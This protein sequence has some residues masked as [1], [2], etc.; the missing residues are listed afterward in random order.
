M[1]AQFFWHF[2]VT[3]SRVISI[4]LLAS[5]F[6]IYTVIAIGIHAFTMTCWVFLL[7]RSPFCS[8][9]SFHSFAFSMV[10]GTVFIF[11]YILPKEAKSTFWHYFCFYT[12]TGIENI[13]A[14]IMFMLFSTLSET[15]VFI[16]CALPVVSF[17]VGIGAM[18]FYYKV[19]HPNILSRRY[20]TTEL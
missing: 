6:P 8:Y 20:L 9:T 10:I 15:L 11:T 19:L 14:I 18:I 16:L 2:C 4:V 7:D 1:I 12:L 17:V 3:F 5:V 13:A